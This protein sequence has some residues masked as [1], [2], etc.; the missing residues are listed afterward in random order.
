V[1]GVSDIAVHFIFIMIVVGTLIAFAF[2]HSS[3]VQ[4][5][6]AEKT[7]KVVAHRIAADVKILQSYPEGGKVEV[8]L[9]QDY[10]I[11]TNQTIPGD[12]NL[13]VAASELSMLNVTYK[14]STSRIPVQATLETSQQTTILPGVSTRNEYRFY[15]LE[16]QSQ[17]I[18]IKGGAC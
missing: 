15:C 13:D 3:M 12:N 9:Y 16:K 1:K 8:D 4:K 2:S 6:L 5:L 7:T 17:N 14:D 18:L 11:S 10:N